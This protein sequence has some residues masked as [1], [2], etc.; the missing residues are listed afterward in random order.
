MSINS[1]PFVRPLIAADYVL[2]DEGEGYQAGQNLP[3]G[4][5]CPE[6]HISTNQQSHRQENSVGIIIKVD[7]SALFE[8][9]ETHDSISRM[10]DRH[11]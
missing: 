7:V 1:T 5:L 4:S 6:K 2:Y 8:L 11:A 3:P 10:R 9:V